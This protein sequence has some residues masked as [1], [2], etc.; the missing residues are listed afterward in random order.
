[1]KFAALF[2]RLLCVLAMLGIILGP[3]SIGMAESAMAMT[4]GMPA[5]V[6][7]AANM[8]MQGDSPQSD[9]LQ[10]VTAA[11]ETSTSDEMPC[12]PKAKPVAPGCQKGCPLAL[13]CSSMILV[14]PSHPSTGHVEI[15]WMVS[16]AILHDDSLTSAD[17]E[18]PARPPRA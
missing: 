18:P 11:G 14:H 1:M 10:K 7:E 15:P 3:V 17:V 5:M 8:Q 9:S 6:Q 13:I 2:Q 4:G 16:F 12:C